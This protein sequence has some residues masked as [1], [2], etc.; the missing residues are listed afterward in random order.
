MELKCLMA[1]E[2]AKLA[3]VKRKLWQIVS[4][5]V[6]IYAKNVFRLIMT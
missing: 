3:K 2:Y 1:D 5:V 6:V 4:I